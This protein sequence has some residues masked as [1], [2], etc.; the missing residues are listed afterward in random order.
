MDFSTR[1]GAEADIPAC[2]AIDD[3]IATDRVLLLDIAGE[4]PEHRVTL[5]WQQ[6]KPAG[7]SRRLINA[8]DE[9]AAAVAASERFWVAE[10]DGRPAGFLLLNRQSWHPTTGDI[11][12]IAV[13]RPYRGR[14][15]G[16]ALVDVMKDYARRA[17]LRGVFWEAQTDNFDA[18]SFALRRGFRFAGF[19]DSSYQSDNIALQ[20][21]ASFR[22]I[23]IY[24]YW[25]APS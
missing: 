4:A 25:T 9:L 8:R 5:S 20:R 16:S 21:D 10:L 12:D 14:G 23:A 24:L 13:D 11:Y 15:V 22:G 1:R 17:G 3:S 6:T 7:S 19:N 2:A 18:I